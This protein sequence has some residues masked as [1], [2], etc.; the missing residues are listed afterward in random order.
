MHVRSDDPSSVVWLLVFVYICLCS[1]PVTYCCQRVQ[2]AHIL[3]PVAI[4]TVP[5]L[6]QRLQIGPMPHVP[7][8][9]GQSC[10]IPQVVLPIGLR[11]CPLPLAYCSGPAA[12]IGRSFCPTDLGLA[13]SN[14]MHIYPHSSSLSGSCTYFRYFFLCI[15]RF[16]FGH[17]FCP[18]T[19][20]GLQFNLTLY[21]FS[22]KVYKL[23]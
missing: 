5:L 12:D 4:Y 16:C 23:F 22:V 9:L 13:C 7:F 3:Y 11:Y 14:C 17:V 18:C 19:C 10:V 2:D 1:L 6:G 21:I 8:T 15:F 20:D